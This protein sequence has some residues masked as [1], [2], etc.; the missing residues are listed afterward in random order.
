M[1]HD[2]R[3]ALRTL[4]RRPTFTAA[5]VLTLALGIGASSAVCSLLDAAL[6]RP[7]PFADP[8]RL[9]F[10]AGVVGPELAV[11][12]LAAN[13]LPSRAAA[14]VDPQQALKPD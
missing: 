12:A 8:S 1:L 5:V 10:L 13:Y 11:V 7:L 4:R 6:L 2:F 14:R 3:F 9:T